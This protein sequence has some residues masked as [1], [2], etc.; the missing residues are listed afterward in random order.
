M[1]FN[2]ECIVCSNS[3]EPQN[4]SIPFIYTHKVNKVDNA[5]E[6][7]QRLSASYN[8]FQKF[9]KSFFFL[10]F[11]TVEI[12]RTQTSKKL[13]IKNSYKV[14]WI[15]GFC[16]HNVQLIVAFLLLFKNQSNEL[17]IIFSHMLLLVIFVDWNRIS[18]WCLHSIHKVVKTITSRAFLFILV[19]T[20]ES[21][22][23]ISSGILINWWR[24]RSSH[25]VTLVHIGLP[26][27]NGEEL[28]SHFLVE[29]CI[30]SIMRMEHQYYEQP[31]CL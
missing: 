28:D 1:W 14:M 19:I 6:S 24:W 5:F 17:I 27:N 15:I 29:D 7:S 12:Y 21:T 4:W 18:F 13:A 20:I 3:I 16:N 22:H 11:W 2:K 30:W 23:V 31:S 10:V 9:Q 8:H 26:L 25:L